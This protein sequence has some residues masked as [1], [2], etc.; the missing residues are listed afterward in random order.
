MK[1]I[2]LSTLLISLILF[3]CEKKENN[4]PI[5]SYSLLTD[6]VK[7]FKL[8]ISEKES[9][10]GFEYLHENDSIRR[11]YLKY[12]KKNDVLI[13]RFDTFHSSKKTYKFKKVNFKIYQ[14]KVVQSHNR[15]LVFNERYGLLSNLAYGAD[16]LFLKDSISKID[17]E[18]LFKE[19]FLQLN[20]INI[21]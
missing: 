6:N 13:S 17:K 14:R 8:K 21:D 18:V 16:Y 9:T 20:K 19:L 12:N 11:L 5:Y 3:S 15:S 4:I 7:S 10:I 1:K 2:F